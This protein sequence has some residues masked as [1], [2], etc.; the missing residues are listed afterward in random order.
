M[1]ISVY[2]LVYSMAQKLQIKVNIFLKKL[3]FKIF[4]TW[5]KISLIQINQ[6]ICNFYLLIGIYEHSFWNKL[7]YIKIVNLFDKTSKM[8]YSTVALAVDITVWYICSLKK[9]YQLFFLIN[10]LSSCII[11]YFFFGQKKIVMVVSY[12]LNLMS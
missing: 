8:L 7:E 3:S 10:E 9:K 12:K 6:P 2:I 1:C 11:I 4:S 5:H